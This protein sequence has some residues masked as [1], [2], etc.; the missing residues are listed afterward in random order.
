VYQDAFARIVLRA[1]DIATVL[2]EEAERL[3]RMVD[4]AR[5]A[6]WAPDPEDQAPCR[7]G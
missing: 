1:E 2:R 6:C 5:A 3:Q 7:V 4:D